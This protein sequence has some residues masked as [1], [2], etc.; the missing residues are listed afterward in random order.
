[1]RRKGEAAMA[2]GHEYPFFSNTECPYFPCHE[3]ADPQ[4]FN[5]LFC[6]CPL[7]L[8]G[9]DCGG[10]FTYTSDGVKDCSHCSRPHNGDTGTKLVGEKFALIKQR[11]GARQDGDGLPE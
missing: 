7:Y 3:G 8:L 2:N 10:S 11:M 1:M 4:E 5:C 9:P 6:Y